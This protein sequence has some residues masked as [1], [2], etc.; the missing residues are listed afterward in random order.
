MGMQGRWQIAGFVM[1]AALCASAQV[2]NAGRGAMPSFG[3]R[4]GGIPASV[5]SLRPNGFGPHNFVPPGSIVSQKSFIPGPPRYWGSCQR[6]GAHVG[7]GNYYGGRY[8]TSFAVGVYPVYVP[9]VPSYYQTQVVVTQ[10]VVQYESPYTYARGEP[11][12]DDQPSYATP[13]QTSP[14]DDRNR[15]GDHYLDQ[16]EAQGRV[17]VVP[18]PAR[19]ANLPAAPAIA[20][21][22]AAAPAPPL[23]PT[24][25]VF[26]DGHS[27]E[28]HNYMI[29]GG[30]LWDISEHLTK[31]F[32]LA[33]L[34]LTVTVKLN[35]ERGTPIKLPAQH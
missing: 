11:A 3:A 31:K 6:C 29:V 17:N 19:E 1:L 8:P 15:Y 21:P 35:D 18:G 13:Y 25:L 10:P 22:V 2:K 7:Y 28:V 9:Y 27:V 30:T 26:K 16:R 20:A 32:L 33:D 14:A 34:D 23:P 24:V 4:P 12:A 5:T